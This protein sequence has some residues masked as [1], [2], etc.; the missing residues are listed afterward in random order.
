M[1][2]FLTG[3]RKDMQMQRTSFLQGVAGLLDHKWQHRDNIVN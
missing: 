1:W 3:I 2:R